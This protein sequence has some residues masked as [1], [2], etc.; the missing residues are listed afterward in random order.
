MASY[1]VESNVCQAIPRLSRALVVW[2][3]G[4]LRV[5]E[6][7]DAEEGLGAHH[8]GVGRPR[9][10]MCYSYSPGNTSTKAVSSQ[11]Q[12][13]FFSGCWVPLVLLVSNHTS[14]RAAL[15]R[16]WMLGSV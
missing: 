7:P 3:V 15:P 6:Q 2:P 13:A 4:V 9:D 1:E 11:E 5:C 14:R 12:L 8:L 10:L 16:D